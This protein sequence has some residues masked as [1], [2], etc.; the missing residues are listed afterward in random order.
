[1]TAASVTIAAVYY[2]MMLRM[3]QRNGRI[4][5]TN[6]IM[7]SL[8]SEEAIGTW[9]ELMHMEWSDY[10]DFERKYGSDFNP[11]LAA[12]RL[13]FWATCDSLGHLLRT[14]VVDVETLYYSG[15][16]YTWWP[17]LKFAP[18]ME[19]H[20]RRYVGPSAYRNWEYLAHEMERVSKRLNPAFT[21][22]SSFDS[23][24]PDK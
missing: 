17:W 18:I 19:E 22:P 5:L 9:L 21:V 13:S 11:K 10:D 7:Q 20:R 4:T 23:Y 16:S 6:S 14:K 8:T 15:V 12:K 2:I 1:M 24:V 3:N